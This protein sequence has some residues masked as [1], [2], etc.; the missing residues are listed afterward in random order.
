MTDEE[1][2]YLMYEYADCFST[3]IHFTEQGV[4]DFARA[5]LNHTGNAIDS[6]K[7][8]PL[9]YEEALTAFN[10]AVDKYKISCQS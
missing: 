4:I 9:E 2:R 10:N 7:E 1:I 5:V 3:S 8:K 6:V